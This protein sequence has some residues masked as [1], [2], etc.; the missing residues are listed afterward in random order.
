[1]NSVGM[2]I[3]TPI[4]AP[5]HFLLATRDAGYR[6]L[7]SALTELI[8]NSLQA[9]ATRVSVLIE[10]I[11]GIPAADLTTSPIAVGVLDNGSGMDVSALVHA[12]QFGGSSRFDDRAGLAHGPLSSAPLRVAV[13]RG[14][15]RPCSSGAN[16]R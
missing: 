2:T 6:N 14:F 4:I 8:D 9:G 10:E 16:V 7:A 12:L 3:A 5:D 1:M 15:R 11:D 13:K